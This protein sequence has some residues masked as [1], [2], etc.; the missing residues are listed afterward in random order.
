MAFMFSVIS[1]LILNLTRLGVLALI[2]DA[3]NIQDG[4]LGDLLFIGFR[5]DLKII[6]S[7]FA[8]SLVFAGFNF[9]S[10]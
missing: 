5:F 3:N 6:A 10:S 9:F 1:L 8:G 4:E 7:I 2:V